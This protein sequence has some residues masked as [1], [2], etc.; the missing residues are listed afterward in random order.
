MDADQIIVLD[1]GR[2]V[3]IGNHKQLL[4]N[5]EIYKQIAASQLSEDE[6]GGTHG[7]ETRHEK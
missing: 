3:G 7:K 4:Q 1:K 6:L 2:V 5:C